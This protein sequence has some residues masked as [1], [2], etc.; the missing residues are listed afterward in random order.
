VET[1]STVSL[2]TGWKAVDTWL[3]LAG[4]SERAVLALMPELIDIR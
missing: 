2:S 4:F 3:A 1:G